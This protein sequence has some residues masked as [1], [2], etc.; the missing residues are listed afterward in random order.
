LDGC[1]VRSL[2]IAPLR[3][4]IAC[5][6]QEPFL[7]AG[8]IRDNITFGDPN[9]SE[10]RLIE[11]ARAAA[12]LD[13]VAGFP[14]GFDTVV[15]EKGIMLSGGQKQRVALARCLLTDAPVLILDDPIS[16]VDFET[17]AAIIQALRRRTGQRTLLIASHRL[18]AL[19]FADRI[20][21]LE[22]GRIIVAGRHAQLMEASDYY[23]RTYR[24]QSIEEGRDE[25]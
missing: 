23:A 4:A 9:V 25:G 8:T 15:G 17:G 16:Q 5:L 18:S 22:R 24:L 3:A 20:V 7:F 1:D 11:A 13:T 2:R 10:Q 6:P 14:Q 19:A 21:V 12:L